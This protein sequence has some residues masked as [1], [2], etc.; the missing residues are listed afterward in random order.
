MKPNIVTPLLYKGQ[1][2]FQ[3]GVDKNTGDIWS[4]KRRKQPTSIKTNLYTDKN[5]D[6]WLRLSEAQRNPKNLKVSYP[7]VGLYSKE[8]FPDLSSHSLTINVHI[9]ACETLKPCPRPRG[10]SEKEWRTTPNTVKKACRDLWQVNHIDHDKQNH[11]PSNLEWTTAKENSQAAVAHYAS[12]KTIE[13][14]TLV[15]EKMAKK[16]KNNFKDLYY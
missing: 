13:R 14:K 11:H 1:E 7:C 10:V 8:H 3:Y 9:L 15:R 12:A 16:E 5:E 4:R 6:T 2:F